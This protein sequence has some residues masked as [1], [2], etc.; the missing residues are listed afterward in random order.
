LFGDHS[1]ET[2]AGKLLKPTDQ[3]LSSNDPEHVEATQGIERHEPGL[4]GLG[5]W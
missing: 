5:E 3:L 1:Q 2:A 4:G